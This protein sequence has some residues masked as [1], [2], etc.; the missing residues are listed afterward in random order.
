M[1]YTPLIVAIITIL[2][3]SLVS[4]PGSP[5]LIGGMTQADISN[6]F[7][8]SV[9]PAGLTFAIWSVIYLFWILAGLVLSG[10]L[11][12]NFTKKY[13]PKLVPYFMDSHTSKKT[14]TTFSLGIALTAVWLLP[15]G[16]LYIGTALIVMLMIL[17]LLVYTF[18]YTRK[19]SIIVRTSVDLI[20]AW[21]MMATA[22]NIT[23]WIRYMGWSLGSPS[24]IYYAIGAYGA[25]L[26]VVSWLQCKYRTYIISLVFIW[27][28]IGVWVAHPIFEQ[29]VAVDIYT[30]VI[31][32]NMIRSYLKAR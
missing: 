15:W 32:I 21:I 5:F 9:T 30:V 16:N 2:L 1:K 6:M 3:T 11:I 27:T 26:L 18:L 14:M 7:A 25:L 20:F 19:S 29:R 24:D 22:L 31:L 10:C 23:V 17:W 28:M 4:I 8:T 12:S 13:L